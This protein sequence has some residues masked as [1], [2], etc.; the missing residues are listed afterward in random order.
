LSISRRTIAIA[1]TVLLTCLVITKSMLVTVKYGG[2]DLRS[3]I[4]GSRLT[5]TTNSPYFYKWN[6]ADGDRYLDP[7][8]H[9]SRIVN[10]SVSTPAVLYVIN[11]L[12]RLPYKDI[13]V[14][15]TLLQ[16][17]VAFIAIAL[18]SRS[19]PSDTPAWLS[20]V[21]V[22]TLG[23]ICSDLWIYNIERGQIYILYVLFFSL[24]Y[25]AYTRQPK[26]GQLIAGFIGGLFIFFRPMVIVIALGFLLKKQY[27]FLLGWCAGVLI[28]VLLLVLPHRQ[29]WKDY[30][31]AM[32]EYS[33]SMTGEE[34][35]ITPSA[36]QFPVMVEQTSNI[37]EYRHFISGGM[38]TLQNYLSKAGL[39]IDNTRAMILYAVL[40]LALSFLFIKTEGNASSIDRLFLFGFL[41]YILSEIM[42]V[43]PRAGYNTIQWIFP[44]FIAWKY[45]LSDKTL[46]LLSVVA[47]L[48]LHQFPFSF[49]YQNDIGELLLMITI[50]RIIFR[51]TDVS[52]LK[53]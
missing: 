50:G 10:G 12:A 25:W 13:R 3:R 29:N 8:D 47:I 36:V 51:K 15:W 9:T 32:N 42:V 43:A 34:T 17:I 35:K 7:N 14:I 27:R 40:V 39:G 20:P 44:F 16:L 31:Q 18:L 1:L 22:T 37:T 6:P 19:T 21:I 11:P 33:K 53:V 2:T 26:A 30:S 45:I 4:V 46:L 28:G 23:F 49:Q 38:L 5:N 48:F 41:L 52:G 24:M